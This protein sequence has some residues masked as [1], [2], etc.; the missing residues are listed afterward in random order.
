[1][2]RRSQTGFCSPCHSKRMRL[3]IAKK[4]MRN[5]R[6]AMPQ[7]LMGNRDGITERNVSSN[8]SMN[9]SASR[10]SEIFCNPAKKKV[11]T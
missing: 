3:S 6:V 10:G 2:E 11:K 9:S 5:S 8:R 1:M 7:K 4:E